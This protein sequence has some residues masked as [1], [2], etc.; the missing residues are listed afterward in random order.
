M[1][2][3]SLSVLFLVFSLGLVAQSKPRQRSERPVTPAKPKPKPEKTDL[4]IGLGL[5]NSVLFLARNT[6]DNNNAIGYTGSLV[7]GGNKP[8]RASLEYTRY[9]SINIEPTWYN[10]KASTL[11]LNGHA[12][13]R[14]KEK[15]GFYLIAGFSYNT[16]S[17]RFTGVNDYLNLAAL[18]EKNQQ[19]NTR[20]IGI[21]T[22]VGMEYRIK[23]FIV[24]G[25][26]KMRLGN[27]EGYNQFNIQ[28]VVYAVGLHYVLSAP[29][30][31]KIFKSP[32]SRYFLH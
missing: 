32:K 23:R 2:R 8:F 3:F 30:L 22:G 16:F 19:V 25:S 9:A 14:S 18:Y 11:E 29:S 28:D 10:I 7:Y 13:Y 4:A 21:N 26:F 15:I 12:V 27:S 17:G 24:S 31:H 20:W 1:W 5:T 6:L